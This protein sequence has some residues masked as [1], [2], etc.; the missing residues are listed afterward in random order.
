M[1]ADN[2][3][4]MHNKLLIQIEKSADKTA[5]GII[6][7]TR[8]HHRK[9]NMAQVMRVGPH[10]KNVA[11]GDRLAF[12]EL[13]EQPVSLDDDTYHLICEDDIL[14]VFEK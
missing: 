14:G 4:P 12:L 13:S 9:T 6:I 7:T 10:V 11:A 5:S 8:T 1:I 2:F 3:N